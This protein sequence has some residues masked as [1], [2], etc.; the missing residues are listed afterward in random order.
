MGER[1]AAGGGLEGWS[2][3]RRA[4]EDLL[5]YWTRQADGPFGGALEATARYVASTTLREPMPWPNS[6]LWRGNPTDAVAQL[7]AQVDGVLAII[8][9]SPTGAP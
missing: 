8:A 4:Y 5:G 3:G 1:M 2:F 9:C 7:K 6:T